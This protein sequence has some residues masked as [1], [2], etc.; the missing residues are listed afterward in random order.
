LFNYSHGATARQAARFFALLERGLL[1]SRERSREML[2][3][4]GDPGIK[5]KFVRGLSVRPEA[6]IYRKS[7][8]FRGHHA[9]AALIEHNGHR[10]IAAALVD[11]PR[12]GRILEK[13]ILVLDD[14]IVSGG[15]AQET[16]TAKT[17]TAR[18]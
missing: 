16:A 15:S 4:L 8:S 5:H 13:L 17:A 1:V 18:R 3:I 9:D 2:E 11:D 12:G 7:G 6:T 10:Y 14:I